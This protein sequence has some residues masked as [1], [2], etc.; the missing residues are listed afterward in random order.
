[1]SKADLSGVNSSDDVRAGACERFMDDDAFVKT[2]AFQEYIW[3]AMK[4]E[5]VMG[6]EMK[7]SK[8]PKFPKVVMEVEF[9]KEMRIKYQNITTIEV[10][11]LVRKSGVLLLPKW[12]LASTISFDIVRRHDAPIFTTE[13]EVI[14]TLQGSTFSAQ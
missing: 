1:M 4:D 12:D 8:S 11:D 9:C 10:K 13:E 7:A 5:Y 2:Q 3:R 6:I 14:L